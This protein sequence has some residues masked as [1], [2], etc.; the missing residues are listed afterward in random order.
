[1]AKANTNKEPFWLFDWRFWVVLLSVAFFNSG[2]VNILGIADSGWRFLFYIAGGFLAGHLHDKWV[3]SD[4][5]R[6]E[7]EAMK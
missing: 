3:E 4:R 7:Q 2:L 6:R 5:A 1:M